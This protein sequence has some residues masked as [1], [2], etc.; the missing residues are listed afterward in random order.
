[1]PN[2]LYFC[3]IGKISLQVFDNATSS[4]R[5]PNGVYVRPKSSFP[6]QWEMP[7]DMFD[8][9]S[10]GGKGKIT[11]IIGTRGSDGGINASQNLMVGIYRLGVASNASSVISKPLL[12]KD[13]CHNVN[14]ERGTVSGSVFFHAPKTSGMFVFRIYDE[15]DPYDTLVTSM[16]W[17]VAAQGRDIEMNFR[18]LQSQLRQSAAIDGKGAMKALYQLSFNLRNMTDMP[19]QRFAKAMAGTMWQAVE[20]AWDQ[21]NFSTADD[22]DGGGGNGCNSK[23]T[24]SEG[25]RIWAMHV[26]VRD[27][28]FSVINNPVCRRL[29][30][31]YGPGPQP[32]LSKVDPVASAALPLEIMLG[33]QQL[34]CVLNAKFYPSKAALASHYMNDIGYEPNTVPLRSLSVNMLDAL[35]EQMTT[36]IQK[37]LPSNDFYITRE[38]L[39]E[40]LEDL[41]IK[42]VPLVPEGSILQVFGSSANGFAMADVDFDMVIMYPSSS[43]A[44]G[45]PREVVEVLAEVLSAEGLQDV[46]SR[47]TARIPIV[48]FKDPET[49]IECDVSVMNP[50]A[51]RNS[52]LLKTYAS[53]DSRVRFLGFILK[54]WA[55]RRNVNNATQGTL[56]SYGYLLCLIY[57]LQTRV[58]PVL[59]NL[60]SLPA[61]WKC[62]KPGGG[63]CSDGGSGQDKQ[64]PQ[65]TTR[66]PFHDRD[67]NTYFFKPMDDLQKN[68]LRNFAARNKESPGQLL[69]SF[70]RHF[71]FEHD[72]RQSIISIQCGGY[73]S[74]ELK[75]ETDCWPLHNR[76]SIE[77]PFETWYDVAHV[78]RWSRH[79]HIHMEFI[80]AYTLLA[81]CSSDDMGGI[82]EVLCKPAPSPFK[83]TSMDDVDDVNDEDSESLR[84]GGV[85]G[86]GRGS[87]DNN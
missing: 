12:G 53:I 31:I 38:C 36:T 57:F 74:K 50:L 9:F 2:V 55:R 48:L 11:D 33:W 69:A 3:Q 60:Q 61:D 64:L 71:A 68:S 65:V 20:A 40:R 79:R 46:D 43:V 35:T 86:G 29:L 5:Q 15:N 28:L 26:A 14:L 16:P 84:D 27:V 34:W 47:P 75:A 10:V 39:R 58:P 76:L 17:G 19:V 13:E 67:C 51:V 22:L 44:A 78:L 24:T 56:C 30:S 59:P 6:V 21:L 4:S 1:M 32:D 25:P 62:L 63:F 18:I 54:Y 73:L 66:H 81:N 72:F 41:I 8:F 77:D 70:F 82:L 85:G 23:T 83:N 87:G 80:R 52:N 45:S 37:L 42:N 7:A 49:G